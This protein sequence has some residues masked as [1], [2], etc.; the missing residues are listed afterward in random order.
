M[1]NHSPLSPS[2]AS[3]WVNCPGSISLSRRYPETGSNEAAAE[4]TASHWVGAT[5]LSGHATFNPKPGDVCPENGVVLDMDMING[6]YC[7]ANTVIAA[8]PQHD[9]RQVVVEKRV[10]IAPVHPAC[11]GTI[12]ARYL[13]DDTLYIDDYKYGW[14]LVDPVGNWQLI[15][16]AAGVLYEMG[17]WGNPQQRLCLRIIQPRPHHPLGPVREWRVTAGELYPYIQSLQVAAAEAMG[18]D[19][20]VCSGSHCKYC[21]ARH[22]CPAVGSAVMSAID[23]ICQGQ[24]DDL[25]TDAMAREYAVLDRIEQLVKARKSG[26]EARMI[27]M[28]ENGQPVP[29]YVVEPGYGHAT[30][31]RPVAE[32]LGL[33]DL[34]GVDLAAAPAAITPV[35]ARA[36]GL[37]EKLIAQYSSRKVTSKK[38]VAVQSGKAALA[39][40]ASGPVQ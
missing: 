1:S 15:S 6:A 14:T 16:Y 17:L 4:G 18:P 24:P 5:L 23:Y 31:S 12:D 2:G 29:G 21:R 27:G 37:S 30:W 28:I 22:A 38:L 20:R 39:F 3:R 10:E 25:T 19:P 9:R 7:Y 13:T 11:F 40:G 34:M 35:Q 32:I 33:G 8:A 36:K 26:H